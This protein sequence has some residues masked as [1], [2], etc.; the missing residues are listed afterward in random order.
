[1]GGT[2]GRPPSLSARD[3]VGMVSGMMV[4]RAGLRRGLAMLMAMG[5]PLGAAGEVMAQAGGEGDTVRRTPRD[6]PTAGGPGGEPSGPRTTPDETDSG[7]PLFGT[8]P[9]VHRL[10][11]GLTVVTVPWDSPGVV[12]YHTLVRVGSRDEVEPGHSG[13]AHLFE[14]MMFRGTERYPAD[15]YE[16]ALQEVGA[17]TNAFTTQDYTMYTITAPSRALSRIVELEADRF[18]HLRYDEAAYRTETGAVLGEY[19]KSASDPFLRMW[20]TLGALSFRRHTYG[21]TTLGYL[22]DIERMPRAYR[23]SLRFFRRFYTPDNTI[24]VVVGDFDRA[25]LLELI[26]QHYGTWRGRRHR[27]R[28]RPEPPPRQGAS[29]HLSW[30]GPTAPRMLVGWRI[31]AFASGRGERRAR[32]LR[33]TAALQVVHGLLFDPSATLHQRLVVQERIALDLGSWADWFHRD[34][35]LFVVHARLVPGRRFD[36]VLGPVQRALDEL[37][38]GQVPEDRLAAV[39]SHLRYAPPVELERPGDV[40]DRLGHFLAVGQLGADERG[41]LRSDLEA[42]YEALTEVG[43]EEVAQVARTYL[44]ERRRFVVTLAA[45]ASAEEVHDTSEDAR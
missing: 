45:E 19:R 26:G 12:A 29:R 36:E 27:S 15:A 20:E 31:P 38:A 7:H 8:W 3:G 16:R 5:L 1:M 2:V 10:P 23:Y 42:Y 13:Y 25:K 14:H 43:P 28:I 34:P 6:R 17:D 35:H 4:R 40:A 11:N 33:E 37:A 39:R 32:A 21:H 41:R 30:S 24:L 22:R 9:L 18:Q 44:N